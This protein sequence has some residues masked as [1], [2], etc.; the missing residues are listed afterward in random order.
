M[1]WLNYKQRLAGTGSAALES[2]ASVFHVFRNVKVSEV[3]GQ[4]RSSSS[5]TTRIIAEEGSAA[6]GSFTIISRLFKSPVPVVRPL[7]I[8]A[9]KSPDAQKF[10]SNDR[11][12]IENGWIRYE[13]HAAPSAQS[14]TRPQEKELF[15]SA[16]KSGNL[17]MEPERALEKPL[18][19]EHF[20]LDKPI[21]WWFLTF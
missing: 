13:S 1:N 14:L 8:S 18:V 7:A 21:F 9:R 12:T 10:R 5:E 20:D 11:Y 6:S 19:G 15:D 2:P 16:L 4:Q 3:N 17:L